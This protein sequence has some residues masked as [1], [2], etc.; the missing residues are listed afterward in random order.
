MKAFGLLANANEVTRIEGF[1]GVFGEPEIG[2]E[3]FFSH[4][5]CIKYKQIS[6]STLNEDGVANARAVL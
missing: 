5:L 6:T 3:R 1:R 4:R 2:R